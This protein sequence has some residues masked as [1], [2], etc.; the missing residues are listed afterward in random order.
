MW[1][2][3]LT[4]RT[5]SP[6]PV[7]LH[8]PR[9]AST[10]RL[11][12]TAAGFPDQ[13][14]H[15]GTRG[16]V[17][18]RFREVTEGTDRRRWGLPIALRGPGRAPSRQRC[19]GRDQAQTSSFK[20]PHEGRHDKARHPPGGWRTSRGCQGVCATRYRRQ[21]RASWPGGSSERFGLRFTAVAPGSKNVF[22]L[23]MLQ[24]N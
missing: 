5:P 23:Q 13:G 12:E 22:T 15:Q 6:R 19:R 24:N 18:W 20:Q 14:S 4:L 1:G 3:S 2:H 10:E 21:G 9:Q 16:T 11:Q 17:C 8:A 7:S